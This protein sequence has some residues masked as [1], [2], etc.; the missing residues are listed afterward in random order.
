VLA[1]SELMLGVS[2]HLGAYV[3]S[4]AKAAL[5][6]LEFAGQ[7]LEMAWRL[8]GS[9]LSSAER[10][11]AIGIEAWIGMR[12]LDREIL[13]ALQSLGWLDT[14]RDGEGALLA[15]D[16][17]IPPA[18][19]LVALGEGVLAIAL[20][21]AVER[22]AL[23]VLRATSRQPLVLEAALEAATDAGDESV[24]EAALRH[25]VAVNL[26]RRVTADDGRVVVFNPNIWVGD[27]EVVTAAL[28]VEDAWIRAEVGALI[29][30]VTARPGIPQAQVQATEERWVDFAVAHGLVQ[31]SLVVTN[32]GTQ[33]AFLFTPHLG[34]DP[35][36]VGR[37]DPSGHVRQLVGSMIYAATFAA[38]RLDSPALFVKRLVRDGEAGDASPIGTDYPMLETAGIVRVEPAT[39]FFKFVLLQS[40]VAEEALYYLEDRPGSGSGIAHGLRAQRS[41]VHVERERAKLAHSVPVD[42]AETERLISALRDTTSRR[43]FRGR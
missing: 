24:A 18:G 23:V 28:R 6:Q 19:E 31:R 27:A 34:R 11:A 2:R 9:G 15:V 17:R 16:E 39:R 21:T 30:E 4:P 20:P 38:Y 3:A 8:R 33:R 35:F 40:D 29:E 26:V 41:Y 22:A 5:A 13:P 43:N 14:Q 36:G 7:V 42:D 10:V 12:P 1:D 37:G 25:L 32:D